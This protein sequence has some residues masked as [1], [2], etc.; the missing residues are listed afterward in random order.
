M[1][2]SE[3]IIEDAV[4]LGL[5]EVRSSSVYELLHLGAKFLVFCS[6]FLEVG[7]Q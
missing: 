1:I 3:L 5:S 4:F 2:A 6:L 7:L